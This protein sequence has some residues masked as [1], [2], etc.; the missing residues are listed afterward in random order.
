MSVLMLEIHIKSVSDAMEIGGKTV[1]ITCK[2]SALIV[3]HQT[4]LS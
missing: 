4:W 3:R 2:V 1:N